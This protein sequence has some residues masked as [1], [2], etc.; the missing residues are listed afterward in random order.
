VDHGLPYLDAAEAVGSLAE[1]CT[2]TNRLWT[3]TEP[4]DFAGIHHQLSGA[5]CNPKPLQ[6][7]PVRIPVHDYA[8]DLDLGHGS[9]LS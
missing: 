3:E 8:G 6:P 4:F 7:P 9:Y 1:S 2:I 5:L